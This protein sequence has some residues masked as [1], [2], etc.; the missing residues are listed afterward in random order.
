MRVTTL[1]ERWV[2]SRD[3]RRVRF[4]FKRTDQVRLLKLYVWSQRYKLPVVQ[5]LDMLVPILRNR[6]VLKKKSYGLGV[7][8]ASLVG[9]GA[10]RILQEEIKRYFPGNQLI[11]I[12]REATREKQLAVERINATE[13]I[14][15][16]SE[17]ELTLLA[18]PS[19][20]EYVRRY[21]CRATRHREE[22]TVEQLRESRRKKRYRG[23]PWI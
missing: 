20:E 17:K 9:E 5:I 1:V 21:R 18:C 11:S 2:E 6:V 10:E 3:N 23:N 16:R 14:V 15:T 13:G 4:T 7:G 8:V 19:V 22:N 12:W